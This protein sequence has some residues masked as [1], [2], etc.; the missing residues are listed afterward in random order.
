[1]IDGCSESRMLRPRRQPDS[2][3]IGWRPHGLN[4]A[5]RMPRTARIAQ[6]LGIAPFR[7]RTPATCRSTGNANRDWW[8]APRRKSVA[9]GGT[10]PPRRQDFAAQ[11]T[12]EPEGPA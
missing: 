1:M 6:R 4:Q 2:Y 10:L 3:C 7:S 9:S 5:S 12:P 8:G 11:S